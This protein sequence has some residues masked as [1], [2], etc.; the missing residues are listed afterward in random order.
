MN[1]AFLGKSMQRFR[2]NL[3]QRKSSCKERTM[4]VE[5]RGMF[6]FNYQKA[7]SQLY[8][9]IRRFF[10]DKGYLEVFTPCLSD[11]LIPEPTI[12]NFST[13]FKNEFLSER[14]LYL[15]PSPEIFMKEMLASGSGS[16]YQISPCFR[17]AEQLGDVHNPEFHMLEYYTVDFDE[18]DSIAL[19]E[20]FLQKTRIDSCEEGVLRTPLVLSV[21]EAMWNYSGLDLIKAQDYG[22]LREHAEKRGLYV[23]DNE[24]WD[25]TFNRIFIT[26]VETNLPTDRPV[27]LTDYPMQ[28]DCLALQKEG[29][30]YRKRWEMYISGVEVAN[31]YAEET[32]KERTRR[33][34]EK[35]YEK[36]KA[37]RERTGEVIPKADLRFCELEI[38]RSSGVAI[39]LDR[40][41]M[42][43]LGISEIKP[44]L[45]FPL[46][47]M[48]N[49]DK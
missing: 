6:N 30:P 26:D 13:L 36:L 18:V 40:L 38:P 9:N 47:D 4:K 7:R 34:Y 29:T 32:S 22:I 11:S 28:I 1:I 31:C 24:S 44:L 23:P 21:E 20:E 15:V 19:T 41:L 2:K 48:L 45:S 46:S 10:D 27:I 14:E 16:I 17:N 8:R 37:E 5:S 3:F 35:E 25:D 12:R 49:R 33:Y 42:T 43:E 39:G